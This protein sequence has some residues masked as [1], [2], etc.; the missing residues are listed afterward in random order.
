M[1]IREKILD[2]EDRYLSPYAV[3]SRDAVRD[4]PI[5]PCPLR[6]D[7]QRDRDKIIHCKSFR[8]LK[9]KTQVFL[10]PEGDHYRTRLTHTLEVAQIG[11]TIAR[12]LMLNEDLVEAI[13][14][15]HDLGHTPFGHAGER[16]LNEVSSCGYVH[17]EQSVRVVERLENGGRGLNLTKQVRDGIKYHSMKDKAHTLEGCLCYYADKIAYMNHDTEDALEAKIITE[18]DIPW[19]VHYTLGR[20]KSE[21]IASFV[22]DIVNESTDHI[23]MSDEVAEAFMVFRE[24]LFEAVYKNPNAKGEETKVHE[25]MITLYKYFISHPEKLKPEYRLISQKEGIER[26]VLDYISGMTDSYSV[27]VYKDIF[28]P[29]SWGF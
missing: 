14:L 2:L 8:R 21:R 19:Q 6:A 18:N 29:R 7:F 9:H 22:N 3:R 15:G 1:E 4:L 11:R 28:V 24:F 27:A 12:A 17:S 16:A 26:A 13:A 20:S 5:E 23:R 10:S 25:M